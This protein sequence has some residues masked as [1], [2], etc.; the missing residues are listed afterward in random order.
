ML[1]QP[2]LPK[3]INSSLKESAANLKRKSVMLIAN[4][5]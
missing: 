4:Q 2:I 5:V 3:K 1:D